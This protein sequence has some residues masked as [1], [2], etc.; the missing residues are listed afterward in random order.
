[1]E[2]KKMTDQHL[3][4]R[5]QSIFEHLHE[6][7]EVSW[8]EVE[9]T[10]YI[11]NLLQQE[12]FEPHTFENMTGL[13]VDIG[14][15]IPKV[16]FRTD[17]DALW[18]EVDGQFRANH[19]CGHD[20]HMTMA[21][22]TVFLLKELAPTLPGAVRIIFQ[23]AEEKA[24]GAKALVEQGVVDSL[25]FLFGTHVR[26]LIELQ[27]GTYAPALHHGA[28]KLFT[29]TINGVEAHGA[30]PEQ[31]VNA[32]EVAAALIDGI[33]R[34]WVSPTESASIK[35]TRLQAGGTASNIIPG[36]ATFSIDARAQ[37]NETMEALTVGFEKVAAA[38]ST[39]YGASINYQVD[40]HIAAAQV[41]D[42]AK[43]IMKQAIIVVAGEE[44]CAPEV[45]TPGGEDFHFFAYSK[46]NL[47]TTMLG[48]GCGVTPGLHHPHM[49][50]NTQRLPIGAQII[51][52]ALVLALQQVERSEK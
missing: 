6:N 43:S 39:M 41:D 51:T 44:N 5:L 40:A 35:M 19:S 30:R 52:R 18:Q 45:V 28:A 34:L 3:A 10:A 46:P 13:Y 24:Q 7:P 1:M 49:T 8:S 4:E 36:S 12:G 47:K 37:N 42:T 33:K 17:M 29:G 15:G 48:L 22:G 20:G 27:D 9:T 14:K 25:Q 31:G 32:I 26:P 2:L 23:P 16:G 11:A 21:L 50:F 38:V